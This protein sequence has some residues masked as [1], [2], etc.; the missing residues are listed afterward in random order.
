MYIAISTGRTS[1]TPRR[2]RKRPARACPSQRSSDPPRDA[3]R[4]PAGLVTNG[5]LVV[6]ACAVSLAPRGSPFGCSGFL[7]RHGPGWLF[8]S[9][10]YVPASTAGS[11]PRRQP[12][13]TLRRRRREP[14]CLGDPLSSYLPFRRPGTAI[15]S[16]GGAVMAPSHDYSKASPQV[17]VGGPSRRSPG[18]DSAPPVAGSGLVSHAAARARLLHGERPTE[19][20]TGVPT[21]RWPSGRSNGSGLHPEPSSAGARDVEAGAGSRAGSGSPDRLPF[22]ALPVLGI[23][24]D[25]R[26]RRRGRFTCPR[27][28]RQ[29]R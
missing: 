23:A 7:E 12:G 9:P 8:G 21:R 13:E 4:P 14:D 3:G 5:P 2:E 24:F 20:R 28:A 11:P 29:R 16:G 10:V 17:T 15:E 18:E 25:W 19:Q 27:I 6:P 26:D 1:S 22:T